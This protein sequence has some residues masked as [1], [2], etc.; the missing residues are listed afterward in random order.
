MSDDG[1]GSLTEHS[2]PKVVE[3]VRQMLECMQSREWRRQS[4]VEY[5]QYKCGFNRDGQRRDRG[6]ECSKPLDE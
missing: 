6:E 1:N 3:R 2:V 5:R 4:R